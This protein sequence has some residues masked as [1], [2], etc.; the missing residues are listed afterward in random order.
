[1]E[2][3]DERGNLGGRYW[4]DNTFIFDRIV[5]HMN[6]NAIIKSGSFTTQGFVKEGALNLSVSDFSGEEIPPAYRNSKPTRYA[7]KEA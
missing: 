2:S 3:R 4:F 5:E 1:M 7:I 6:R